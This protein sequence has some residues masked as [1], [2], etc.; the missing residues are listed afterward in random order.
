MAVLDEAATE[1]AK[2]EILNAGSSSNPLVSTGDTGSGT[3]TDDRGG[4]NPNVDADTT[5][6]V[7]ITDAGSVVEANGNYLTYNVSLSNAVVANTTVTRS[8]SCSWRRPSDSAITACFVA[9]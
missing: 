6:S 1:S 9:Q 3:I 4:D 5:A 7:V 2:R 8:L